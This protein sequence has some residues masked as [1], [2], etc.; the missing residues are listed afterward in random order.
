MGAR[1]Q[2]LTLARQALFHWAESSPE[3]SAVFPSTW[4]QQ[5][6]ISLLH[7]PWEPSICPGGK[8]HRAVDPSGIWPPWSFTITLVL[9]EP[10]ALVPVEIA[11]WGKL[12]FSVSAHPSVVLGLAVRAVSSLT[13]RI[14][15]E[16][17]FFHHVQLFTCFYGV[18]TFLEE[19]CWGLNSGKHCTPEPNPLPL[20]AM[21]SKL[22]KCPLETRRT[23]FVFCAQVPTVPEAC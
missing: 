17:V 2:D 4:L 11:G 13:R 7:L 5:K 12:R 20:G 19:W 8:T 21:T 18:M 10:P 16:C 23:S 1:T 15:E 14:W 9:T 22:L 6:G 3:R